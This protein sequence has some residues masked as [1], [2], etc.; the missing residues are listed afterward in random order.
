M[1]R[2]LA[3]SSRYFPNLSDVFKSNQ[4][5]ADAFRHLRQAVKRFNTF[6][7]LTFVANHLNAL[8]QK[9]KEQGTAETELFMTQL[10]SI[11]FA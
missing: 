11:A 10:S 8:Q 2:D 4:T 3:A 6:A 7:S 9:F 5:I 1:V